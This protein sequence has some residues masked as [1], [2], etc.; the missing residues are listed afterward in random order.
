MPL[1]GSKGDL[2]VPAESVEKYKASKWADEF[3]IYALDPEDNPYTAIKD[4]EGNK[5]NVSVRGGVIS[6]E[7]VDEFDVLDIS[8]RK[9]PSGRPLP[10]GVYL[11]TAGTGSEKVVVK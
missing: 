5:L 7:G 2:Y 8:G 1:G 4:V 6:V 11:V 3:D 10:A 9:M